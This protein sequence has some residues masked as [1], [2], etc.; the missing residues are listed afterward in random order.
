MKRTLW[1]A[2]V[3]LIV[4][5]PASA[6]A[7]FAEAII[8]GLNKPAAV[9]VS[10]D[11][12]V[13]V[14]VI[15]EYDKDGDGAVLVLDK[16]RA[17]P[18]ATGLD[19]PKGLA[20]FQ[21]WLY[22]ADKKRIWRIDRKGKAEVFVPASAFPTPPRY[23]NGLTVDQE[24]GILYVSDSG[25]LHGKEGAIF[26]ISPGGQVSVVTDAKSWPQL[27]LP[28]GLALDGASH[29]LVADFGTGE[30]HRIKLADGSTEKL[31]DGLGGADSLAWDKFGRLYITDA[32][33]GKVLV[34]PRPGEKPVQVAAGFQAPG[35]LCNDPT[36]HYLYVPDTR[37]G[38]ITSLLAMAPG[39]PVDESPLPLESVL[40]FPLLKWAGWKGEDEKGVVQPLRPVVLTHAGDGSNRVFVA[41]EQGVIHVFPNN[42]QATKTKV[43]LDLQDRVVYNDNQNEEG[44]LGLAFHPNYKKNG[45]F[46]VFY[47]LKKGSHTN[48][49][50]RFRVR[51]DDP[52]VADP[53]S[54]EELFR[55]SKP[56]WNH[57][58]G[59]LCFG[60]DGYLYFAL[61]D[62]G[63]ANDPFGNGQNLKTFLGKVLRID[64]DHK[65]AGKN[66]A[67]PKDNPF[68]NN[69]GARPE[70][71]AY[72][73]RNIWRMA[74]DRKTGA[75]W[76]ADVGQNL[77]EEIDILTAGGN[78]GW[79]RR[80]GL[81]PF[82]QKGLGAQ[83][84]FIEPIWEYHH[85]V[86]KSITGGLV[87][88]G[89]RLP[90]LNG[91]YVYGDYVAGKIW[92]LRYSD[93]QK[94]V[95]ANQPIKDRGVPIMSFGEDE[96]GEIYYMTYSSSGQGIYWFQPVDQAKDKAK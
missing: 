40:A 28:T 35:K 78:Y 94:R 37:A 11:G 62:G 8:T 4:A 77:Y 56:F 29:L 85:D 36:G 19:D 39:T 6:K 14:S 17:I 50:S 43:F 91:A 57:N 86:G 23:L 44:F 18:F 51:S 49:L 81:H 70:I 3:F 72:G 54:E 15:G 89:T 5:S 76:A 31:A 38:T 80:E 1:I 59:T 12:R 41:T 82:G 42:Q 66:Y 71:W 10:G 75:L 64:V 46:F 60:P 7:P 83:P 84:A 27:N 88:R 53:A 61:G 48:V 33:G 22:V 93:A 24:S 95:V 73:L 69:Q 65:D 58:G 68:V 55:V 26:R 20:A 74:F 52:N 87:F 47:T 32:R 34:F 13:F 21:E 25:D 9:A 96:Q 63:A 2:G 45:E 79:N 30:L 90:E 67:I 92:A 16:N